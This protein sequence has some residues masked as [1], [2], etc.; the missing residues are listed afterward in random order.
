[1]QNLHLLG[2]GG[3]GSGGSLSTNQ[4][5][6]LLCTPSRTLDTWKNFSTSATG[7]G[8]GEFSVKDKSS[9][10]LKANDGVSSV[11]GTRGL[12]GR[13]LDSC[14]PAAAGVAA[15][16]DDDDD[17]DENIQEIQIEIP[18]AYVNKW[19]KN[20]NKTTANTNSNASTGQVTTSTTTAS[21][22]TGITTTTSNTSSTTHTMV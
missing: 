16:N 1:M 5:T 19:H 20:N 9:S 6:N 4:T 2:T 13:Y 15:D 21:Q 10:F 14:G 18:L 11:G 3:G 7:G 22:S 12:G 17:G 8:G